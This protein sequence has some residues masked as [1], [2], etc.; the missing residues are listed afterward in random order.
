MYDEI[1]KLQEKCDELFADKERWYRMA[2]LH[3]STIA[4]LK[5]ENDSLQTEIHRL[6]EEVELWKSRCEDNT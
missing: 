2:E 4:Q 6:Q 3:C 1:E 5:V